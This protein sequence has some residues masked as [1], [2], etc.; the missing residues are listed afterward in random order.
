MKSV[1]STP[2]SSGLPISEKTRLSST[3]SR[4]YPAHP[5]VVENRPF[6]YSKAKIGGWGNAQSRHV[7]QPPDARP[8]EPF[9]A[10]AECSDG[11]SNCGRDSANANPLPAQQTVSGTSV[12]EDYYFALNLFNRKQS[13]STPDSLIPP[14]QLDNATMRPPLSSRLFR[15]RSAIQTSRSLA[16]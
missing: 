4:R 13:I 3:Q 9:S 12:V 8:E 2:P 6:S 10:E 11:P 16:S 1:T 5:S 7:P 14:T 15:K